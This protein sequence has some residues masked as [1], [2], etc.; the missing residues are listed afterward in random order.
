MG[1]LVF[2]TIFRI[3]AG[4]TDVGATAIPAP[5]ALTSW[6]L[7]AA[8]L[9]ACTTGLIIASAGMAD[10]RYTSMIGDMARYLMDGVFFRDLLFDRP[11]ADPSQL[12]EYTRLYY[13]RYPALSLGHHPV[14]L[15][16][17]EA[18]L[19]ALFGISVSTAR[20][21]PLGSLLVGTVFLLLLVN[22]RYGSLAAF[23]AA[24]LFV[25][26][27]TIVLTTRTVM[28]EMPGIALVVAGVYFLWRFCETDRRAALISFAIAFVLSV[29]ARPMTILVAPALA[30][31]LL[32]SLPVR[33]LLRRD[34]LVTL[35][36]VA[37]LAAPALAVP[38]LLSSSNA[39]GVMTAMHLEARATF[40]SLLLSA[41][42]PQLAWPVLAVAVA[43]A[44]RGL[45]RRDR[46]AVVLVVWVGG[47]VPAL[48]FF[49]GSVIDGPRYTLYWVPALCALAG[50][51][52]AG[53]RSRLVPTVLLGVLATGLVLQINQR[54][55]NRADHASGYEEAAQF[56][57]ASDP[58]ATVMFSGDVD[59]GYFTFFVRKHDPSRRLVVLRAD[60]ILTTSKMA[61]P[62]VEDRI[63]RPEEIYETLR[64][65]GTR[66]VV[67]EDQPSQSRVL[68]WLRQELRSPRFV[69]RRRIPLRANDVRLRG[70]SLAI[71]EFLDSSNPDPGATLSIHLPV[72][73]QSLDIAL[74]DLIDRK[75]LK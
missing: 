2:S 7:R 63:A 19:F 32:L 62:S 3:E 42:G 50:S 26:S 24:L 74:Q 37:I 9:G 57:L 38:L 8:I 34:V 35:A 5:R 47:V 20:I 44:L 61:R 52:L 64:E 18:P 14:L 56:V 43:A 55:I 15:P 22:R 40:R 33:R 41:L 30:A 53:W 29:Y 66:Y 6:K 10:E 21:V 28:A 46:F 45:L 31:V 60:K 23:T 70:T 13:A 65:F 25:T 48:M 68:E 59:T 12:L 67:I 58:G 54:N 73:G 11:F 17:M 71:Y 36:A 75:L 69:E 39:G 49:G 4:P 51:S 27:P 16:L 1:P 72:V